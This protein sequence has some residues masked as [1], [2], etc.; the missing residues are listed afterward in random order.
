M[1]GLVSRSVLGLVALTLSCGGTG[2]ATGAARHLDVAFV[3]ADTGVAALGEMA[4]GAKAAAADAGGVTLDVAAPPGITPDA[5][6]EVGM[7]Q[8]ALRSSRDGVAYQTNQPDAFVQPLSDARSTGVPLIAIDTPPPP[9]SHVETYIGNSD[10]EIGQQL[11]TAMLPVIPAGVSGQVLIGT[12][13]PGFPVLD[14]RITGM[15]QVLREQRPLVQVVG[16]FQTNTDPDANLA[17]WTAMVQRYPNA[18]AYLAPADLDIASLAAIERQSNRHLVVG[19]CDIEDAALQA[20]KDGLA[21]TL[22]SPE[23]WLKGYLSVRLLV[24]HARTGRALPQG[25]WNPGTLVVDQSNVDEV[26]ARQHD[27]A[28]RAQWFASEAQKQLA[29]RASYVK[30]LSSAI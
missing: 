23:H 30:P 19:G 16:P 4:L 15:E 24:D 10:F 20:V 2:G 26:I 6:A 1:R 18:L 9:S 25:W 13:I 8:S 14:Q 28:S 27:A 12:L 5:P 22:I 29:N 11:A 21:H 3:Y 17:S 7:L